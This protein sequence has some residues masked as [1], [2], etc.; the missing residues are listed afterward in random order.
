V[1]RPQLWEDTALRYALL[2]A[3][4]ASLLVIGC[5]GRGQG[6]FPL[7]YGDAKENDPLVSR[8]TA[9]WPQVNVSP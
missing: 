4:A 9:Y 8:V 5:S 3:A 7:Q 1:L 6:E 2:A